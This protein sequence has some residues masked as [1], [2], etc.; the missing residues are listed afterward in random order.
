MKTKA[1]GSPGGRGGDWGV[2]GGRGGGGAEARWMEV[3]Q[4][5][6]HGRDGRI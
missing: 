2:T 6:R 4:Q 1:A 5:E 3:G